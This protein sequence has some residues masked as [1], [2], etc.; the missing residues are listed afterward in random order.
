MPTSMMTSTR[1][2]QRRR[3]TATDG[4]D[5]TRLVRFLKRTDTDVTCLAISNLVL[6]VA[7][8]SACV[9]EHVRPHVGHGRPFREGGFECLRDL[10]GGLQ[11]H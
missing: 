2:R 5:G 11:P 1:Q 6:L 7:L 3:P 8:C 9:G 10:S 4:D